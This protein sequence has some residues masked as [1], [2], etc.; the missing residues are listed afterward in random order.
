MPIWLSTLISALSGVVSLIAI[1]KFV[2]DSKQEHAELQKRHDE[3]VKSRERERIE[4]E[5]WRK[6]VDQSLEALKETSKEQ[7]R[8]LDSH[9]G[10]AQM[11]KENTKDMAEIRESVAYIKGT[12]ETLAQQS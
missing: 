12:I 6:T 10:Y 7:G 8:R 1:F 4:N 5:A 3:E 11:F 2:K 9:N